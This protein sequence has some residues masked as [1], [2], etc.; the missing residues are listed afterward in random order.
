MDHVNLDEFIDDCVV[1]GNCLPENL[2]YGKFNLTENAPTEPQAKEDVQAP[3]IAENKAAG[4]PSEPC[5]NSSKAFTGSIIEHTS[6]VNSRE[7]SVSRNS[8]PASRF[9]MQ[10]K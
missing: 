4:R 10:R 9:K 5:F 1:S 3:V 6:D 2:A 8:K 7:Q